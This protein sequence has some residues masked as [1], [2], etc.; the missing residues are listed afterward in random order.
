MTT[1]NAIAARAKS[2][3]ILKAE[4]DR[5]GAMAAGTRDWKRHAEYWREYRRLTAEI[6][7]QELAARKAA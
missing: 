2:M 7:R 6:L 3:A 1:I 4:R 5:Y